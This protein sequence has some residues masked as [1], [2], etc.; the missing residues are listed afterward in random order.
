VSARLPDLLARLQAALA[1]RY[2]IEREL[3]RGGMATVY[4]AHDPKHDRAVAIKVLNPEVASTIGVERFLREIRLAARLQHPHILPLHDSGEASGFLYYVMP[5]VAGETLRRRL[6]R[7]RQLPLDDALRAT[8]EVAE[9]LD[10]AHRQ[11][12]VHRDIKPENVLL[13]DGQAVVADFGIAHAIA[14]AADGEKLTA[15]G[16]AV[17][18]PAYMS[19]EQAS[20]E[21][22]LDGRSDVYSLG[23]VLYEM[24]AG[25]PPFT[26]PSAQAVIA[27]RLSEPV[28]HLGTLRDVPE[29]VEVAVTKALAR[30]P[31]DRFANATKFAQALTVPSPPRVRPRRRR[32]WIAVASGSGIV[33]FGFGMLAL[34]PPAKLALLRTLITRKPAILHAR[35]VVVAPFENMTADSSLAQLGDMAADWITQGLMRTGAVEV[36]DARTALVTAKIVEATPRLLRTGNRARALAEETGAATVVSG[37]YYREG[38]TLQFQTQITDAASGQ[39]IGAAG[40][41]SGRARAPTEVVERLRQ[42]IMA[43]LGPI[44]DTAH[45]SWSVNL[46][47]PPSYEAYQEV[48]RAVGSYLRR[49]TAA[50]FMHAAKAAEIDS[51]YMTPV[52]FASILR[53]N[54]FQFEKADSLARR[55]EHHRE[56]LGPVDRAGLDYVQGWLHGSPAEVL[57]SAWSFVDATPG[58][59]ETLVGA[60]AEVAL[61]ENRPQDALEALSRTDPERGLNLV[62]GIY[63][64]DLA[65]AHHQLGD[66]RAEL[67]DARKGLRQVPDGN[68]VAVAEVRALAALGR[69]DEAEDKATRRFDASP[70]GQRVARTAVSELRAHGYS[71]EAH[72][73]AERLLAKPLALPA[74]SARFRFDLARMFYLA[75][76]WNESYALFTGLAARDPDN[77]D[78]KGYLGVLAARR[79]DRRE[80]ERISKW[81]ASLT[82]PFLFGEHTYAR[83]SIAALLGE[84]QA[85]VELLRNAFNQGPYIPSWVHGD[86]DLESLRDYPPF[87]E[88]VRPKG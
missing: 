42:H 16:L 27:K 2:T 58:S 61:L 14:A 10:Y 67:K 83:A 6:N 77:V 31:A 36:V 47:Q 34:A 40:P 13:A 18:T 46:G 86:M 44:L 41:V 4:L 74:D 45:R 71:K 5:Y 75:E 55:A 50:A 26:G 19:P 21:T 17:G 24:L 9:A 11:G 8:R 7:E 20:G 38:D 69:L 1:D 28:P 57:R 23:C 32:F 78:Y 29:A 52:V 85:A 62:I 35:R 64:G 84:R 59:V 63:W 53:L 37:R 66:Y 70:W 49:D 30:A 15:T 56:Q 25:E 60:A 12:V 81:L 68:L 76:R 73:L 65:R 54:L 39:L 33:A 48:W 3:G 82:R 79:G 51:S 88:L 22:Q 43:A 80:A 72:R 87:Q